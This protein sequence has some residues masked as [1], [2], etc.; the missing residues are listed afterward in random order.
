MVFV[1]IPES[2]TQVFVVRML[3]VMVKDQEILVVVEHAI[4][5]ANV[6]GR[7]QGRTTVFSGTVFG[8]LTLLE[9]MRQMRSLDMVSLGLH[10]SLETLIRMAPMT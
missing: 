7:S 1:L 3:P 5:I 2:V 10:H 9:T 6:E 8:S 4:L